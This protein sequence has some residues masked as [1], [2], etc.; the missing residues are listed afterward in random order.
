[1]KIN[2]KDTLFNV[3]NEFPQLKDYFINN[4]LEQV[5]NDKLL[6]TIGKK[7]TLGSIIKSKK[8]NE[9]IFLNGIEDILNA[10]NV[11]KTLISSKIDKDSDKIS[12]TGVLPCPVRIPL[13]E[14][15]EEFIE[16]NDFSDKLDYELKAASSGVDWLIEDLDRG[17]I[18]DVFL[19]AGFDLFFDEKH[20]YKLKEEGLFKDYISEFPCN[21]DFENDEISLRDPDCDYSVISVVPA[22]FLVNTK[23]LGDKKAPH[24]WKELLSGEYEN[25]VSLPI[26]DFDL[27]NAILL[28]LYKKY[29]L[30][31]VANLGKVLLKSMHPSE[32]VKSN[33]ATVRPAITIMPYFFTKMTR[34]GGEMKAIWPSDGAIISPIFMVT[35]DSS[36]NE[37]KENFIRKIAEFFASKEI[38]EVL[39]HTGLFPSTNAEV[40]NRIPS[41]NKYMWVGW[42]YIKNEDI[43]SILELCIKTFDSNVGGGK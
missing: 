27:F 38:G 1:M 7:L 33:K 39:S 37:D 21:K 29:G 5:A 2:T 17:E 36:K 31:S 43:G 26:G 24:S 23:E 32:M 10:K 16:K 30:E 12:L 14:K 11:D 41:E 20:M 34:V 8:I 25:M 28:N 4:G 15:L 19:S 6:S 13:L 40:D 22:V 9:E 18:A 42:D 3:I 35:K